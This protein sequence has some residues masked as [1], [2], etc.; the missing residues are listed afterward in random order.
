MPPRAPAALLIPSCG[1]ALGFARAGWA[2]QLAGARSGCP[3]PA[4]AAADA[5]G[6]R[7][8]HCCPGCQAGWIQTNFECRPLLFHC[9]DT[10]RRTAP[11]H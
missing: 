11:G 9:T 5:Q 3:P 6:W 4:A 2:A 7:R 1:Y 10:C 8:R